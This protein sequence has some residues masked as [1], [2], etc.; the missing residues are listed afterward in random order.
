MIHHRQERLNE[1]VKRAI[2]KVVSY[3][4]RDKR[5]FGIRISSVEVT[6]DLKHA[7]VLFTLLDPKHKKNAIIGLNS[8]SGHIRTRVAKILNLRNT[9]EL[10]FR[11]DSQDID[12][13]N[14]EN[15]IEA[16][17]KRNE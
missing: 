6:P 13:L 2:S 15:L 12:A 4:L 7:Y 14:L 10:H 17:R 11:Y 16:E 1:H 3:E 8:A 9:P 5:T